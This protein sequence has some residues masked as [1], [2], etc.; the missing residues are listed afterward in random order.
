MRWLSVPLLVL[1]FSTATHA[2]PFTFT[3]QTQVNTTVQAPVANGKPVVANFLT[4]R[5]D[6][7][8]ADGRKTSAN[9]SC[10]NWTAPRDSNFSLFGAC[11]ATESNG[12]KF[13][14]TLSCT[15]VDEANRRSN[16]WGFLTGMPGQ[17]E[18]RTGA[19]SW[20]SQVSADGKMASATGSGQWN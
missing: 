10:A 6:L 1:S 2:Q 11:V 15:L 19:V 9:V 8:Y 3:A 12:D 14:V 5:V 4:G 18:G 17:Y 7:T 13:S 16:C 20:R